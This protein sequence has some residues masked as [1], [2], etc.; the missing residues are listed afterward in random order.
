MRE[1]ATAE[2]RIP[3][4]D[5]RCSHLEKPQIENLIKN[6]KHF[7]IRLKCPTDTSLVTDVVY[8]KIKMGLAQQDD[9]VLVKSDGTPTY[10]LAHPIDD[11]LMRITHVFR[12]EEWLPSTPKHLAVFR[13]LGWTPPKYVHLPLLFN[14]NRTKLSKRSG[15]VD[16]HSFIEK[17]YLPEAVI[18]FV[19]YLGWT[20]KTSGKEVLSLDEMAEI[21][22]LEELNRG[23]PIVNMDKLNWFNGKYI[24]EHLSNPQTLEAIAKEM[25]P[26]IKEFLNLEEPPKLKDVINALFLSKDKLDVYM[27]ICDVGDYFFKNPDTKISSEVEAA[28]IKVADKNQIIEIMRKVLYKLEKV[29]SEGFKFGELESNGKDKSANWGEISKEISKELGV[30]PSVVSLITRISLTGKKSG[31]GLNDLIAALGYETVVSRLNIFEKSINI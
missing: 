5:K 17:G 4:Y 31:P 14:K 6:G 23:N 26:K 19:A 8:G 28:I 29:N 30:K 9:A 13:G 3:V 10:H 20:P 1:K 21:F 16:V 11:H 15:D 7:T 22:S 18:N 12:G 2:G 25:Q 27:D 24:S